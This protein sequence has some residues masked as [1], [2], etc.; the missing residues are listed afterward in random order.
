[1]PEDQTE[2]SEGKE[3]KSAPRSTAE[4]AFRGAA[5][6]LPPIFKAFGETTSRVVSQAAR[7]LEEE[8]A[9]GIVA[10]RQLEDKFINTDEIRSAKPDELLT[11]FRRDAHEVLDIVV[12]IVGASAR[13]AGRMASRVISIRGNGRTTSGTSSSSAS[14]STP[15]LTMAQPVKA[16]ET[17]ELSLVVEND[18]ITAADPFEL[19]PTDLISATGDRVPASAIEFDPKV[20]SVAPHQSQKVVVRITPP[21]GTPAGTYSGLIQSNRPDQMRAVLTL[22]VA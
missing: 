17:G 4:E 12:D 20:V 11:R 10:A 14:S 2:A 7:I 21:A 6:E 8:I 19:R 16:G 18:G 3:Q 1:M 9:A 5:Q 15:V 13:G 22:T